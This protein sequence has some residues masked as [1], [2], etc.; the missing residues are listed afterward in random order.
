VWQLDGSRGFNSFSTTQRWIAVALI[1]AAFALARAGMIALVGLVAVWRAFQKDAP[2]L[3]NW[4]AFAT[5]AFLL[6]ALTGLL[7]LTAR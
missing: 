1:G 4:R 6:A 3:P 2:P 5:Y 7:P